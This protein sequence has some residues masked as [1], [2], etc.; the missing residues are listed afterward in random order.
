VV[1]AQRPPGILAAA[2]GGLRLGQV[3]EQRHLRRGHAVRG[4]HPHQQLAAAGADLHRHAGARRRD[5]PRNARGVAT[6]D[7]GAAVDHHLRRVHRGAAELPRILTLALRRRRQLE[8]IAPAELV[9]VIDMEGQGQHVGTARQF[10][11]LR[12]RRRTGTAALRCEKLDD[13][14]PAAAWGG[15]RRGRHCGDQQRCNT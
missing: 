8:A 2:D 1:L 5:Q 3:T 12:V 13:S 7:V 14:R 15:E 11:E 6:H 10:P 4:R 9:P